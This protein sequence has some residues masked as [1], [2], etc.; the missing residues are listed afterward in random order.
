MEVSVSVFST[1]V[2]VLVTTSIS[3]VTSFYSSLFFFSLLF[4]T[5]TMARTATTNP[6]IATDPIIMIFLGMITYSVSIKDAGSMFY[7]G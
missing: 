4:T 7:S 2:A 3:L 1:I 5:T 6:K